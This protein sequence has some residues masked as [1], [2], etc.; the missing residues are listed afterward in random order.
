MQSRYGELDAL[1]KPPATSRRWRRKIRSQT[2]LVSWP[3]R[4]DARQLGFTVLASVTSGR[5]RRLP[6]DRRYLRGQQG[7]Y[8]AKS[9]ATSV[10]TARGGA[11]PGAPKPPKPPAHDAGVLAPTTGLASARPSSP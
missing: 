10:L 1:T 9:S 8:S 11:F 7:A 5:P 3:R 4:A 6:G 2:W